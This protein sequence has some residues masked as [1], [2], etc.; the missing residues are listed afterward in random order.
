MTGTETLHITLR[1]PAGL[2]DRLRSRADANRRS[3]NSEILHSLDQAVTADE[4]T[5]KSA[6]GAKLR[7]STIQAAQMV[8]GPGKS[9]SP[10][11]ENDHCAVVNSH[12]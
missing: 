3:L 9:R 2:R 4:V 1:M 5:L 11:D 10:I 12:G 7:G 8:E 6:G